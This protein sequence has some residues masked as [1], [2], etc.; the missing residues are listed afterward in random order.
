M[1]NRKYY[2]L[3]GVT[4]DVSEEELKKA[5]RKKVKEMHP[6][7]NTDNPKAEEE[8]KS[9]NQA[10][11]VLK[12][13]QSRA[14]YDRFGEEGAQQGYGGGGQGFN[15]N[16]FGS[17]F[18]DVFDDLFGDFVGGRRQSGGGGRTRAA[19]GS[20]LRYNLSITLE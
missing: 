2:D 14:A 3:L 1:S 19:R 18:S 10:Y 7:R 12:D 9:V 16:D 4:P 11:E 20:D 13:P 15:P 8:F 6:D 17:A 5:F